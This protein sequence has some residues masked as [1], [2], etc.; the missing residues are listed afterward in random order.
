MGPNFLFVPPKHLG[1][2]ENMLFLDKL[3]KAW[4]LSRGLNPLD[5]NQENVLKK[6]VLL[7]L[8]K[9]KNEIK[10]ENKQGK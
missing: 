9:F 3:L 1:W 6:S 7:T 8:A 5:P 4:I 10:K 2:M